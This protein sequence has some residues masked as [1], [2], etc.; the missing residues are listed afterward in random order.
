[1]WFK[2]SD[3]VTKRFVFDSRAVAGL[4]DSARS[5]KVPKPTRNEALTGFIWKHATAASWAVSGSPKISIAAH[6]VNLRPRMRPNNN[7]NN[8]DLLHSTGNLFWWAFAAANPANEAE[9]ELDQLVGLLKEVLEGFDNEFLEKMKG[10]DG[11]SAVSE[12]LC[13][14]EAMF[15]MDS[16][17]PDIFAFTWWNSLFNDIDFGQWGQGNPSLDYLGSETNGGFGERKGVSGLRFSE[18]GDFRPVNDTS[19]IFAWKSK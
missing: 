14:I 18:S 17:K 13:Q 4:S 15:S 2:E 3:Y 8:N 19:F 1:M 11:L 9:R 5:E 16:D 12:L 10:E 6:A 7:N